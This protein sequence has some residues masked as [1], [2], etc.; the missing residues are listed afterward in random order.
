MSPPGKAE[1]RP[2]KGTGAQ[3]TIA[4]RD[5]TTIAHD[6]DRDDSIGFLAIVSTSE[7]RTRR[8]AYLS[9][10]AAHA[11]VCRAHERGA[12]ASVELVELRPIGGA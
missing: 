12:T 2:S 3:K 1:R 5:V 4:A 10:A 6:S 11:A 8:R 9:L 7:G